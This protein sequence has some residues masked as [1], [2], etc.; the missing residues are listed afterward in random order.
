MNTTDTI[1][2]TSHISAA[3]RHGLLAALAIAGAPH[4]FITHTY[5]K[6]EHGF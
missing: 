6:Q 5:N 1:S 4:V 3:V 2:Y